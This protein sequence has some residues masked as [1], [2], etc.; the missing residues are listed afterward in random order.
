M[1]AVRFF[2]LQIYLHHSIWGYL[3]LKSLSELQPPAMGLIG[4]SMVASQDTFIKS[5]FSPWRHSDVSALEKNSSNVG[6][7]LIFDSFVAQRSKFGLWTS[8]PR[9]HAKYSWP[10]I[11]PEKVFERRKAILGNEFRE[12]FISG[13]F[14]H[15]VRSSPLFTFVYVISCT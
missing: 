14:F 12:N 10:L 7:G 5:Y 11:R 3:I 6:R 13:I 9:Y 4:V 15:Y 2:T 8:R 1:W